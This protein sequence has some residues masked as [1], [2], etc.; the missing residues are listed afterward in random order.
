MEGKSKGGARAIFC[1]S[2]GG[3]GRGV[4]RAVSVRS[5][6]IPAVVAVRLAIYLVIFGDPFHSFRASEFF[7]VGP[8]GRPWRHQNAPGQGVVAGF[9]A[10]LPAQSSAAA[11]W[12]RSMKG[13]GIVFFFS[14]VLGFGRIRCAVKLDLDG[15]GVR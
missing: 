13:D 5:R 7:T 6:E 14:L 4:G 11:A 2:G 3:G 1:G 9:C 15:Y 12:E 8:S 10:R